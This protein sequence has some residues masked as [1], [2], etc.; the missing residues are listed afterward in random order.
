MA[1][2]A[3]KRKRKGPKAKTSARAIASK[4][5][6]AQILKYRK[7]GL[8]YREIQSMTGFDVAYCHRVVT[9]YLKELPQNDME[10]LRRL[11]TERLDMALVQI[12]MMLNFKELPLDKRLSALDRLHT[13]IMHRARILG[14]E[15][16][17][18]EITGK[19]GAPL[20]GMTLE[21]L[22]TRQK[23]ACENEGS[24]LDAIVS[25]GEED[26]CEPQSN[27]EAT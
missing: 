15:V 7:G 10:A 13:N 1:N 11:E 6:Q 21:E 25:G 14:L 9:A 22:V 20:C 3:P 4:E 27:E 18:Q 8:T 12:T 2:V 23:V 26:A 24:S 16:T 5:T 17:K 19:D